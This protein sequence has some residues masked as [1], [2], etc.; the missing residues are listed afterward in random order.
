MQGA[1]TLGEGWSMPQGW[2]AGGPGR[3]LVIN[4]D[5]RRTVQW[6]LQAVGEVETGVQGWVRDWEWEECPWF[7]SS[8][9]LHFWSVNPFVLLVFTPVK[10]FPFQGV[11][12]PGFRHPFGWGLAGGTVW[13][14]EMDQRWPL[15]DAAPLPFS[16]FP[17]NAPSGETYPSSK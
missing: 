11:T 2:S 6:Q 9:W 17:S 16:F 4:S 14:P 8:H 5:P 3:Q 7:R 12:G 13:L 15:G 10:A 1:L